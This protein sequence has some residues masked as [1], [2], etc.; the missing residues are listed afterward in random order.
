MD[1]DLR[2]LIFQAIDES[3]SAEDFERLQDAIGQDPD[4]RDEYLR[5]VSLCDSLGE[6][7]TESSAGDSVINENA[8]ASASTSLANSSAWTTPSP[9][10]VV[11]AA[12]ICTPRLNGPALVSRPPAGLAPVPGWAG[13]LSRQC[14]RDRA[15]G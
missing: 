7:A 3:I 14:T 2:D 9:F 13:H 6:L 4:F 1:N 11:V 5:A 10:V 12:L 8:D 15:R